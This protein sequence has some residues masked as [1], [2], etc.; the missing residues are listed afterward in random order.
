MYICRIYNKEGIQLCDKSF[1]SF[2]EARRYKLSHNQYIIQ[3]INYG[4]IRGI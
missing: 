1:L 4:Y 2:S 3:I